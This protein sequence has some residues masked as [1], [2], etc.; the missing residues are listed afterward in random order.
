MFSPI[1]F[2]YKTFATGFGSGYSPFAPGTAGAVVGVIMVWLSHKFLFPNEFISY[3]LFLLLAT[4]VFFFIGVVT[5]NKLESEWGKD[6]SKIV[7]DEIIGV[8][9]GLLW[10]PIEWPWILAAFALFRFFDILKPLGIRKAEALPGGWGVMLDDV[11]AG[12]YTLIVLQLAYQF[13][14]S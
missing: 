8:W 2:I 14:F 13:Y 5:T 12:V 4:I 6:P 9:I 11:L 3:P 7:I 1:N 10:L